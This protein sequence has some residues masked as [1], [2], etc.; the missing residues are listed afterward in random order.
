M[1]NPQ[2]VVGFSPS[3]NCGVKCDASLTPA[4]PCPFFAKGNCF[5]FERCNFLHEIPTTTIS[6]GSTSFD[7]DEHN[8]YQRGNDPVLQSRFSVD[9]D[10]SSEDE[11]HPLYGSD[12]D[13]EDDCIRS[14]S[15]RHA[16][17]SPSRSCSPKNSVSS[18]DEKDPHVRDS[19]MTIK[20]QT[21]NF[22]QTN[23]LRA[24]DVTGASNFNKGR[25]QLRGPPLSLSI[26]HQ[27]GSVRVSHKL[28]L[29]DLKQTLKREPVP[30]SPL[31]NLSEGNQNA[32]ITESAQGKV[33][34]RLK[35]NSMG[36]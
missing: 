26:P 4:R 18:S 29:E 33:M 22:P 1:E 17:P 5:F 3:S 20:V 9:F 24:T 28:V 13:D 8:E 2:S 10:S 30:L 15:L 35:I 32:V 7:D 21:L 36:L 6:P 25:K 19:V 34:V 27:F 23:D 31:E 16:S 14:P 11:I 12:L